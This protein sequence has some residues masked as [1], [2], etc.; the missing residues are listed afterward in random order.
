MALAKRTQ[1]N[2]RELANRVAET[3]DLAPLAATPE[4][5]GPGFLNV[6]LVD[7]SVAQTLESVGDRRDARDRPRL[8]PR[9]WWSTTRRRTSPSRCHVGHIRSTVIGESLRADLRGPGP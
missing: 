1:K 9:R 5:A 4:V 6:R 8:G 2:P 3:V 7:A